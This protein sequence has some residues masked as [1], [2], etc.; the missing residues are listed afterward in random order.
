M[1]P[2]SP[3]S[4]PD[5]AGDTHSPWLGTPDPELRALGWGHQPS[6]EPQGWGCLWG[7]VAALILPQGPGSL[8]G[9]WDLPAGSPSWMCVLYLMLFLQ[10][11]ALC[12]MHPMRALFLIPRNPAPRLKSKK[13]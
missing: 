7:V 1:S 12:D 5:S 4:D 2:A 11:A 10:I 9:S 13:W 3:C 8:R 6:P